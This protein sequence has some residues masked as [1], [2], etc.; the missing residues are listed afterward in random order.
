MK[1]K[2]GA[3]LGAFEQQTLN[4][5]CLRHTT[6]SNNL[7]YMLK[8]S[9]KSFYYI[10]LLKTDFRSYLYFFGSTQHVPRRPSRPLEMVGPKKGGQ[11]R[12]QKRRTTGF[13]PRP[14][15]RRACALPLYYS[16]I[17]ILCRKIKVYII[18]MEGPWY[19]GSASSSQSTASASSSPSC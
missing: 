11:N 10:F 7:L 14:Q 4:L 6:T 12:W 18:I 1:H 2:I 16:T 19:T 3:R 5:R 9:F 13:E 15:G 17:S 8:T